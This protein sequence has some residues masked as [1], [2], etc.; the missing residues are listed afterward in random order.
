MLIVKKKKHF[1]GYKI[2][3]RYGDRKK[4]YEK[5]TKMIVF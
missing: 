5:K 2:N 1:V 3:K 4:I